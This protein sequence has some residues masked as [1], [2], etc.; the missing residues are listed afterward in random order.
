MITSQEVKWLE[1]DVFE[2]RGGIVTIV[3]LDGNKPAKLS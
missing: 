3:Q 2:G 1:V